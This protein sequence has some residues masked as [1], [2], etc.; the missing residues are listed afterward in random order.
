VEEEKKEEDDSIDYVQQ[1]HEEVNIDSADS[2]TDASK[3]QK[4]NHENFG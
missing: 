4:E 1:Y 2:Q 3:S